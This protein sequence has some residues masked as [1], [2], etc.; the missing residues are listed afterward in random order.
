MVRRRHG[1]GGEHR[2]GARDEDEAEAQS[3]NEPATFVGVARRAEAGEGP[4]DDLA[5]L[6][7][8]TARPTTAR[9]GRHPAR[10]GGLGGGG[11]S[12]AASWRRAREMLKL[13]TSAGD[14]D[15]GPPLAGSRRAS[16][17]HDG[18]DRDDAGRQAGDQ[19]AE[20]RDDEELTHRSRC[21]AHRQRARV[22]LLRNGR[23]GEP[24][25]RP[26]TKRRRPSADDDGGCSQAADCAH[27]DQRELDLSGNRNRRRRC[28]RI[29]AGH[30]AG[31][32]AAQSGDVAPLG[33]R[34]PARRGRRAE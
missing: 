11:G 30:P 26:P 17:H 8:S 18:D 16:G 24:S 13:T 10:T 27:G 32:D 25:G 4:L 23:L 7:G 20:E 21:V 14:D 31:N 1:D 29:P 9:A 34:A 15:V 28:R 3:E 19:P 5:D 33:R 2:T 12:R 22:L 6:W